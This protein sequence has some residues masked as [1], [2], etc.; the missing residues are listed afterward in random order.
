MNIAAAE[1]SV[2]QATVWNS[3]KRIKT[4]PLEVANGYINT[5]RL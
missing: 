3:A 2:A 5:G 4:F 1:T